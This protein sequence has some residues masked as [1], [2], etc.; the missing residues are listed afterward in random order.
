MG[1][2]RSTVMSLGA[3]RFD[4]PSISATGI[5]FDPNSDVW[6]VRPSLLFSF[7]DLRPLCSPEF[8][9]R[10]KK[11]AKHLF[12]VRNANSAVNG[13]RQFKYVCRS[14]FQH[15]D[16]IVG[17]PI[18]VEDLTRWLLVGRNRNYAN[19]LKI[20]T[21]ASGRLK[22]D[23]LTKEAQ[24]FLETLESS[25]SSDEDA[26]RSW[27]PDRGAYR[28]AED[29]A[30][31]EAINDA[32]TS[33]VMDLKSYF[34]VSMF[35]GFGMRPEQ[36]AAMKYCDIR[37]SADLMQIRIPMA[38]QRGK[39]TRHEFIPWKPVSQGLA[40]TIKLYLKQEIEP[41]SMSENRHLVPLVLYKNSSP[42]RDVSLKVYNETVRDH[43][44]SERVSAI[45]SNAMNRLEIISPIYECKMVLNPR[46]E[47]HTFATHLA[48][49]GAS[50]AEIAVNLGHSSMQSCE[51]YI[52]A[53]IGHFQSIEATVGE[54][55]VGIG[56]RFLGAVTP[57][58]RDHYEFKLMNEQ[59]EAVGSCRSG[60][61]EAVD[62]GVAPIACYTCRKFNAWEDGPHAE[63]LSLLLAEQKGLADS[64]HSAV[65]ETK[66]STILAICNL[67]DAI[68]ARKAHA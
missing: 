31:L 35:R 56:D 13:Y 18:T 66:T 29:K 58:D 38:K 6:P 52:D 5:E 44:S 40:N 8:F 14:I 55:Y 51:A 46:R 16:T 23:L 19:I 11:V 65:A 3:F 57:G 20:F 4:G 27:D 48:M 64:G 36:L 33:G 15:A 68:Q 24:E 50:A 43:V 7:G 26:V 17:D 28:P 2:H 34:V 22:I 39:Q 59:F 41:R 21:R 25:K 9:F 1:D 45:Y 47:R 61:C 12:E 63:I 42:N 30:I 49:N 67:L 32:F 53:T 62:A 54:H 37:I 10:V 60:G